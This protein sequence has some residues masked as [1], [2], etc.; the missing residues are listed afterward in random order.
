MS[1]VSDNAVTL[2]RCFEDEQMRIATNLLDRVAETGR[3]TTLLRCLEA[4][5]GLLAAGPTPT[6]APC[7]PPAC[8]ICR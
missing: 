4:P 1:L 5:G 7:W 8:S 3:V 2:A 6:V